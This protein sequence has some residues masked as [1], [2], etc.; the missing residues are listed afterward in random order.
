MTGTRL[1]AHG[2]GGPGRQVVEGY[3][4]GGFRISGVVW[5][6]SVL[7]RPEATEGWP[8]TAM[9]ELDLESL[10]P[11]FRAEPPEI[12][13]I[14]CGAR[15]ELLPRALRHALR[16]RGTVTDVMDTGAACRTYDVLMAEDRRVAAALIA[17]A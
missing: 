15:A 12:L 11:L 2:A 8:V 9:S 1:E 14:G 5:N 4:G 17:V 10:G 16:Q 3:G 7:V 6:G 13:L